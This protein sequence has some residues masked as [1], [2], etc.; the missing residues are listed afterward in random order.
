M[1]SQLG[2]ELGENLIPTIF[3]L[4]LSNLIPVK[5]HTPTTPIPIPTSVVIIREVGK[6]CVRSST[7][8]TFEKSCR[9]IYIWINHFPEP[10]LNSTLHFY[11]LNL[12]RTKILAEGRGMNRWT[13][14]AWEGGGTVCALAD[15][16]AELYWP[17]NQFSTAASLSPL[18]RPKSRTSRFL[19]TNTF[20]LSSP[21]HLPCIHPILQST[22]V[23]SDRCAD[24]K[25]LRSWDI[26]DLW[27]CLLHS[28]LSGTSPSSRR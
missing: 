13:H 23:T 7:G 22:C 2:L 3:Q 14:T 1:L 6:V 19:A 26:F 15:G 11:S 16:W 17:I 27:G 4:L 9:H 5:F 8:H 12:F 21:R 24:H 10:R 25:F 20:E 18:L 28:S